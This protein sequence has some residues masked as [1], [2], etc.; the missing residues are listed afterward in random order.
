MVNRRLRLCC[1]GRLRL[2]EDENL[3]YWQLKFWVSE[4]RIGSPSGLYC[5]HY[6]YQFVF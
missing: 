3:E 5:K 4:V 6:D 1:Y 2:R